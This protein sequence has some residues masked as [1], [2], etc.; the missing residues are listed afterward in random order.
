MTPSALAVM[1]ISV[2]SIL[3]LVAFCFCRVLRLPP[4]QAEDLKSPLMID[5]GDV[6]EN[7]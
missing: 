2:G 3:A 5:A 7:D 6:E 4:A 1:L